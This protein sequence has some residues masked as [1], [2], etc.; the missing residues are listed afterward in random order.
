MAAQH[1]R[2]TYALQ[3][4]CLGYSTKDASYNSDLAF[5]KV[6]NEASDPK[7]NAVRHTFRQ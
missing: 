1:M 6:L 3:S 4:A 7:P 5:E 2:R